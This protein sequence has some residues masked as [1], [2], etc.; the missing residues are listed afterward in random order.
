MSVKCVVTEINEIYVFIG[1]V[2]RLGE[3]IIEVSQ[4]RQ[5][6]WKP[7]RRYQVMD[8]ALQIQQTGLTG[9]YYRVLEEGYVDIGELELLKR[10]Y[11]EW[12]IQAAN[13]VM[14]VDKNNLRRTHDLAN[15][16]AL[17]VNWRNRLQ[18]RLRGQESSIHSRVYGPNKET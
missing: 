18:R 2:Y 13:E 5:P 4:P 9:W 1:D 3:A 11:P 10:P 15:C 14:H 17:A 7:A 8:L 12:S 6:C 16:P